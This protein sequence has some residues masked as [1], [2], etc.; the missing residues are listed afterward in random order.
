MVTPS[1]LLHVFSFLLGF[2]EGGGASLFQT[3]QL[4]AY[5]LQPGQ[6]LKKGVLL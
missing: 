2:W 4:L 5:F 1:S 6:N 3:K